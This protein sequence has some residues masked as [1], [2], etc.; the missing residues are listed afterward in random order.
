MI[1]IGNNSFANCI[2]RFYGEG[3]SAIE[4][5]FKK[6]S[7][8]FQGKYLQSRVLTDGEGRVCILTGMGNPEEITI[9]K[10]K[11][12]LAKAAKEVKNCEM[13][14]AVIDISELLRNVWRAFGLGWLK[15]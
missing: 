2:V 1:L 12:L 13:K 5:D 8:V 11:E 7:A 6:A 14:E 15:D 4:E 10:L 3:S 9:L